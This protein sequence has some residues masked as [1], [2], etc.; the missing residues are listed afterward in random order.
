MEDLKRGVVKIKPIYIG[1]YHYRYV[2]GSVM[3]SDV[4]GT[5]KVSLPHVEELEKASQE[6]IKKFKEKIK[7]LDFVEIG[8]PLII[9]EHKDMRRVPSELTYDVDALLVGSYG[10]MPL[11]MF[12]LSR[13]RLPILTK[14]QI[15][16]L[17]SKQITD[18]VRA[19]RVKKFLK[20]SKVLYIGEIPSF[21]AP[22][23]PWD[24]F[25][26]EDRLGVRFRHVETNEF[27]RIFDS[28]SDEVVRNKL[29]EWKKD[30]AEVV[31][32]TEKDLM[33]ATR[34]YL[35]LRLLC[36]R[37]DANAIT[38]NCGRFTEE[39]P[40]V[41]CIAFARLIDE[42][43]MCGCEGDITAMLSA[44]ILHASSGQPVLMGNFGYREGMFGAKK[45]EVTIE[46][47][48]L[49]LS[50]A[51]TRYRVRDYHGRRFGVT[52]YADIKINQPMTLL[53]IDKSLSKMFVAEG[54]IKGSEDGIHCRIII[55]MNINGDI[56]KIPE[57]YV[58]SQHVAMTFG[59]WLS[60][61]KEVGKLLNLEIH[62]P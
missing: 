9:K 58:G 32:P 13:Y 2:Y 41:P 61:L 1:L 62:H 28:I 8:A 30:F 57:I 3:S 20:Q 10:S 14:S 54:I 24:F 33:D 7:Q 4:I 6:M 35:A 56:N 59:H 60:T 17:E 51:C 39:R 40:V 46:H 34:V 47:D 36:D 23:G 48:V 44:L 11:E 19:L 22:E 55:H 52:A 45:G 25:A 5:P 38:I 29:E 26:I 15:E 27:F 18:F 21:S 31:E 16:S 50:M 37:E 49:P 42:G 53:N 43:I 12:A